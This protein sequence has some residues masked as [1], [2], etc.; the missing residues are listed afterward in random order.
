MS[1]SRNFLV[2]LRNVFKYILSKLQRSFKTFSSEFPEGFK[3]R[4][5]FMEVTR[6]IQRSFKE[7]LWKF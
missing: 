4:G 1:V 3:V 2:C 7:L 6:V 5:R